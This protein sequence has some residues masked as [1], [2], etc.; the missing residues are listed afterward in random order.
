M[1]PLLPLILGAATGAAATQLA[2]SKT[3]QN[4]LKRAGAGIRDA[5]STGF[6]T[7]KKTGAQVRRT[8][9][10]TLRRK[11]HATGEDST[12][13]ALLLP[14]PAPSGTT[15]RKARRTAPHD[16]DTPGADAGDTDTRDTDAQGTGTGDAD[17]RDTGVQDT[18]AAGSS[19]ALDAAAR[20]ASGEGGSARPRRPRKNSLAHKAMNKKSHHHPQ[21][22]DSQ[23]A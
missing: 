11:N 4:G 9:A 1:F 21:H 8:V 14:P 20:N 18:A 2:R 22:N 13:P 15:G 6:D 3:V 12:G 10:D 7:V 17:T 16:A 5:A 19:K 23:D